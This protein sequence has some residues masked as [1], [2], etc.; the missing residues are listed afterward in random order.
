MPEPITLRVELLQGDVE[1]VAMRLVE[2][3]HGDLCAVADVD[4]EV[5]SATRQRSDERERQLLDVAAAVAT[6]G[7]VVIVTARRGEQ[8]EADEDTCDLYQPSVAH[9][10]LC[11]P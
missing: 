5:G 3:L 7:V 4:A 8:R 10:L 1:L 9:C 2:L 11:L 6:A